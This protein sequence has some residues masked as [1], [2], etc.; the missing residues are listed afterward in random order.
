[1]S[2]VIKFD[3]VDNNV[4]V[5]ISVDYSRSMQEMENA[6]QDALNEAGQSL[7][8]GALEHLD[9]DGSPIKIGSKTLTS[10]G[11]VLKEYETP[12]GRVAVHR[13]VYQFPQGG[14][15]YC[16]MEHEAR[17]IKSCTPRFAN[18][19]SFKYANT[20]VSGVKK[21]LKISNHR[22]ISNE[23]IHNVSKDIAEFSINKKEAWTYDLP[24]LS[25][26][27]STISI[28]LDGTCVN[29][30]DDSWREVMVGT[31]SL[32]SK[33]GER[34]YTSYLGESPEHGKM[35]FKERFSS[36][37]E[38]I[39]KKYPL[40]KIVGIADGAKD[41][42]SFLEKFTTRHCLDFFHASEYVARVAKAAFREEN[43]RH[44]WL[45]NQLHNLKHIKDYAEVLI[46][47][48]EDFRY[49]S[50]LSTNRKDEIRVCENY[51][52]NNKDRMIYAEN[53]TNNIP[54]GS[55]VV[56]AGCKVLV[57]ERLCCSG[58][59]WGLDGCKNILELRSLALTGHRWEQF[60]KKIDRHGYEAA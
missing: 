16:P 3:K 53:I 13:H 8:A 2:S 41:N 14:S 56:E 55:G 51:F 5:T 36:E 12:Y 23:F 29:I 1:M 15:T 39:I 43:D 33:E 57:K 38:Y 21:D 18:I 35:S 47:E 19:I 58:M 10:K 54:I 46:K 45:T 4:H 25:Q 11:K 48:M 34:L 24:R 52:L 42:W 7:T 30:R 32:Y 20:S 31:V 26:E 60:W 37:I 59:R 6:I 40:A 49:N 50:N 17:I 27:V 9:T 44:E 28:S 22:I